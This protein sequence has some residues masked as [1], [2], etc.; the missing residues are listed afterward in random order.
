MGIDP[1][2]R[3]RK[4]PKISTIRTFRKNAQYSMSGTEKPGHRKLP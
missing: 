2:E 1:Y 3:P 4:S